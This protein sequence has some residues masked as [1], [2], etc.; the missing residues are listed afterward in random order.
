LSGIQKEL[1]PKGFAVVAGT[2]NDN[3][4]I[5][6]FMQRFNPGFPVGEVNHLGVYE[7]L[8]MNPGMRVFVPYMVFIDRKGMIRSQ[9]TG[10]D[11]IMDETQSG[12]LLREEALKFLSESAGPAKTK[13]KSSS[14]K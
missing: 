11:K 2:L 10:T 4:N 1:G 6:D 14:H 7:Y 3:P 5:P 8:Q 12:A 9:Y 13:A